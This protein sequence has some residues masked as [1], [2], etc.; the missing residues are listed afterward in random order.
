MIPVIILKITHCFKIA[1]LNKN[2]MTSFSC[3]IQIN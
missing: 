1:M 2:E 3:G